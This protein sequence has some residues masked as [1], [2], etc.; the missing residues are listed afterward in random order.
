MW[1]D[2]QKTIGIKQRKPKNTEKNMFSNFLK[3]SD[4]GGNLNHANPA[5]SKHYSNFSCGNFLRKNGLRNKSH[6]IRV[7]TLTNIVKDRINEI[8]AFAKD[9][10]DDFV[11]LVIGENCR[12]AQLT[13]KKNQ[14]TLK[15]LIN[16]N[17]ELD[18]LF[19]KTFEDKN[20]YSKRQISNF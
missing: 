10:R 7:E 20:L 11:S 9:F 6:Y 2:V 8:V 19:E 5:N 4:C 16:R 14:D 15:R 13:K 3:C 17:N 1:E 12:Q 18:I